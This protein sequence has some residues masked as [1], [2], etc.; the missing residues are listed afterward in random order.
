MLKHRRCAERGQ[1]LV[2]FVVILPFFGILVLGI[3]SAV[4]VIA[5]SNAV[6]HGTAEAARVAAVSGCSSSCAGVRDRIVQV[7]KERSRGMLDDAQAA[8]SCNFDDDEAICVEWMRGPNGE[9]PGEIGAT[10]RVR[11][12]F[13]W[14]MPVIGVVRGIQSCAVSKLERRVSNP[15]NEVAAAG[16]CP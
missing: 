14:R 9:E 15:P 12:K 6:D 13:T 5:R 10:V 1:G 4:L 8:G 11:T 2:E 3:L 16:I 7:A